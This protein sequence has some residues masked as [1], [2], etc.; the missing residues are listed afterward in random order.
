M[1]PTQLHISLYINKR[2]WRV[3]TEIGRI[4][5][6]MS[7]RGLSMYAFQV[8]IRWENF[9][10]EWTLVDNVQ[11]AVFLNKEAKQ[12]TECPAWRRRGS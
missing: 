2:H 9:C 11:R 8:T 3:A 7:K 1:I 10:P 6:D 12:W 4:L 5:F